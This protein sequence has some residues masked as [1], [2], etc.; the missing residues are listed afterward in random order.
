MVC[1]K[2]TPSR[3]YPHLCQL[4]T[5]RWAPVSKYCTYQSHAG[6]MGP[7]SW[8]SCVT[9]W[10]KPLS[11]TPRLS[12][13]REMRWPK[14]TAGPVRLRPPRLLL[15]VGVCFILVGTSK[16]FPTQTMGDVWSETIR[17]LSVQ[18]MW[19]VDW[20]FPCRVYIDSNH[21]DSQMWVPLVCGSHHVDNLMN[22][23]S[24]L[25]A[26]VVLLN[27]LNCLQLLFD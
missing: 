8:C 11:P 15:G 6:V 16:R 14:T 25:V 27:M 4:R 12:W 13:G 5:N 2:P 22:S 26:D 9:T 10:P 24:L 19:H 1:G 20:V 17:E 7:V 3:L 21:R 18:S 23:I